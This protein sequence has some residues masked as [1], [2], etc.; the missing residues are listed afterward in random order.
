MLKHLAN[1]R[2]LIGD[3][4][5]RLA[6][7]DDR[8]HCLEIAARGHEGTR[9]RALEIGLAAHVRLRVLDQ[10]AQLAN[11][12][13]RGT[14]LRTI[15]VLYLRDH[16]RRCLHQHIGERERAVQVDDRRLTRHEP[17]RWRGHRRS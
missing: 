13:A 3:D 5:Q 7:L 4:R 2:G 8:D 16:R 10:I 6:S 1:L 17:A 15:I 14:D 11:Q 12:L 9:L